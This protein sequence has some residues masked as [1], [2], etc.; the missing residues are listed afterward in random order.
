MTDSTQQ[1]TGVNQT[2]DRIRVVFSI[3][4]LHGGGSERQIVSL[5]QRIDRRQFA[6]HLYL[7]YRHGPLL[8]YVP[9]D[10]PIAVFEERCRAS[11]I[12]IPGLMHRR[13][14]VDMT[15]YLRECRA[16][17]SYDR[18]F[19]MTLIAADAAQRAGV[20]SVSTIVTDPKLGF[21]PVA[22]RFQ[23]IKRRRLTR[24]YRKSAQVLAVSEGAARSAEQFYYL[25]PNSVQAIYNGFDFDRIDN[26]SQVTINDQWWNQ[27][28]ASRPVVRIVAAGRLNHEKGFH[29]LIDAVQHVKQKNPQIQF[30]TAILGDGQG[31]RHT[32][33]KQIQDCSLED[34]VRLPGFR[35][36]ALAWYRSADVF[37]LSSLLE[38]MP[39]VLLEAMACGTPVISADCP[40]GPAEILQG[41]RYG[42]LC[43]AN[44]SLALR[45]TLQTFLDN[46]DQATDT[47]HHAKAF[48]R[49]QF[50]LTNTVQQLEQVFL[51]VCS[52]TATG[53]A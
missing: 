6:P 48:V 52:P 19:L 53:K 43:E 7:I 5:L 33:Q 10:V 34:E 44:N 3:G 29:L 22:G 11:S 45:D 17:V 16:D 41:G 37:V 28:D 32:L 24:L 49:N 40:S 18:T 26:E 9:N 21:A 27:K 47:A 30:I 14:V 39:N 2:D 31:G 1:S 42:S 4:A 12:Y 20:P 51:N 38:G 50:S 23:S 25:E 15:N 35:N 36:D 8:K 13:R 46:R